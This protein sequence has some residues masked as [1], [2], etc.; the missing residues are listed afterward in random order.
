MTNHAVTLKLEG[1]LVGPW[2]AELKRA[3]EP[4]LPER[5]AISLDLA[6]VTFADEAGLS[7][8]LRLRTQGVTLMNCSPFLEEELRAAS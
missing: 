7:L 2:V 5:R 8:L 6:D 1:R 4:H 3:C